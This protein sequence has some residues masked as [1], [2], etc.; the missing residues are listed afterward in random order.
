MDWMVRI[1][2]IIGAVN[3][4]LQ[5]IQQSNQTMTGLGAYGLVGAGRGNAFVIN[6]PDP[7]H[8]TSCLPYLVLAVLNWLF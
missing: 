3:S 2:Y 5:L 8:A 4:H 7:L 6:M 1:T